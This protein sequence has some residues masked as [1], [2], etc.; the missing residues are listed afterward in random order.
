[1][2]KN[3]LSWLK[4]ALLVLAVPTLSWAK[5]LSKQPPPSPPGVSGDLSEELP[6]ME[7]V[8]PAARAALREAKATVWG[9]RRRGFG[10]EYSPSYTPTVVEAVNSKTAVGGQTVEVSVIDPFYHFKGG[11]TLGVRLVKG[12]GTTGPATI[13]I[14]NNDWDP[15][16]KPTILPPSS[17]ISVS[18]FEPYIG[19]EYFL[20]KPFQGAGPFAFYVPFRAGLS[21]TSVKVQSHSWTGFCETIGIGLGVKLFTKSPL[22]LDISGIYNLAIFTSNLEDDSNFL[23]ASG[24]STTSSTSGSEL[25][26]G[27]SL[28]F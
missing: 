8:K 16:Y 15:S 2:T 25:R 12:N 7:E 17:P 6:E 21:F 26:A 13:T 1:M 24:G 19:A 20:N 9:V 28:M 22:V 5:D 3:N 11:W 23:P 18:I 14:V 27:L 4:V 10:V